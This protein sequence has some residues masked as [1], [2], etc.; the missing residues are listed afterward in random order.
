MASHGKFVFE[1]FNQL[2]R[3]IVLTNLQREPLQIKL[4]GTFESFFNKKKLDEDIILGENEVEILI[5]KNKK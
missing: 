1:R 3:V 2:E 5:E 4:E